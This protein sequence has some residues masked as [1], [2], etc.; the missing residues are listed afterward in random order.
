MVMATAITA[1][2]KWPKMRF[3]GWARG[4]SMVLYSRMAAAPKEAMMMGTAWPDRG[5]RAR[6]LFSMIER[7]QNVPMNIDRYSIRL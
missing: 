3:R 2:K 1:E 7:P 5:G 4:D 6:K